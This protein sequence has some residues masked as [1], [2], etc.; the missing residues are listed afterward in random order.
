MSQ[1][2]LNPSEAELYASAAEAWKKALIDDADNVEEGFYT[3][4]QIQKLIGKKST[5]TLKALREKLAEGACIK[6]DFKVIRN[7]KTCV[8]PH[9]KLK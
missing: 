3:C 5:A 7:G 9:Y 6:K 4:H 8:L 1:K 2:K